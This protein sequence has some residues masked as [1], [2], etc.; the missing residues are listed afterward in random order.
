MLRCAIAQRSTRRP[1][2]C[3]VATRLEGVAERP[4]GGDVETAS[5]QGRISDAPRQPGPPRTAGGDVNP[6]ASR[7]CSSDLLHRILE[8]GVIRGAQTEAVNGAI[9]GRHAQHRATWSQMIERPKRRR[10]D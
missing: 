9:A 4:Q 5:E 2:I 6:S 7:C 10:V 3:L 8:G 1:S